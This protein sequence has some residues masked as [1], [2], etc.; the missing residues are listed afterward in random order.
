MEIEFDF[1]EEQSKIFG[2]ILRP[3][4][5]V[6]FIYKD[7]E[8]LE[9]AYVDSG[10]DISLIPKSL[11]E[12]L[13][14][15]VKKSDEITEIKGIG[16]RSIPIIIKNIHMRIGEKEF[17]TRVAWALIEGVPML[18]GREDIFPL[19]DICFKKN[20]KTLFRYGAGK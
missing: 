13:G 11:G 19:F 5:E 12:A 10:A 17:E 2:A 6:I 4:A 3:V 16:E 18:L 15:E 1:R 14:I 8:I 20:R 7:K 9:S